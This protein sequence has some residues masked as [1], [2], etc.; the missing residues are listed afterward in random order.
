MVLRERLETQSTHGVGAKPGLTCV[1]CGN[2]FQRPPNL[3]P[4]AKV[5]TSSSADHTARYEPQPDGSTR[6]VACRCCSCIYKKAL[7]KVRDLKGKIIPSKEIST[8]LSKAGQEYGPEIRLAFRLGLNAMLRVTEITQLEVPHFRSDAT[9]VSQLD[10]MAIKKKAKLLYPVDLDDATTTALTKHLGTRTNGRIFA[11]SARTLQHYFKETAR[12][13]N[14]GHLSIHSLR[15]TGIWNRARS[16]T[17]LN[18]LNYLRQQARHESI[19]T[20]KLYL[21]YEDA[22]RQEMVKKVAWF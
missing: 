13:L 5:C 12:A 16:V 6:K 8:L 11:R 1:V 17:N 7:G 9:P 22:E 21:G 19:E 4:K 14:L 15:H 2:T 18:D 10:V 20:T 3:V